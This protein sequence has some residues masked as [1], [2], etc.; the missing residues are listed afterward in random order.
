VS[1]SLQ[2]Q[3]N[4]ENGI[5]MMAFSPIAIRCL[6][7]ISKDD[8]K[9]LLAEDL[10]SHRKKLIPFGSQTPGEWRTYLENDKFRKA[11]RENKFAITN[12]GLPKYEAGPLGYMAFLQNYDVF[13]AGSQKHETATLRG[14]ELT[15]GTKIPESIIATIKGRP[16]EE[17]FSSPFTDGLNIEIDRMIIPYVPS[18]EETVIKIKFKKEFEVISL[19][20]GQNINQFERQ[21]KCQRVNDA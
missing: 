18:P 9:S 19:K 17:I 12:E 7:M 6:S 3:E 13:E 10:S 15:I 4:T 8:Y 11:L 14:T 5:E 21:E 20:N 16:L 2:V 1:H